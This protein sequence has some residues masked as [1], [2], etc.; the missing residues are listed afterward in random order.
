MES[1]MGTL[2]RVLDEIATD[3]PPEFIEVEIEENNLAM[4]IK[5]GY[6]SY[7]IGEDGTI[8]RRETDMADMRR[9]MIIRTEETK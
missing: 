6:K 9:F 3:F 5:V 2:K 1:W 4:R 7:M 8:E